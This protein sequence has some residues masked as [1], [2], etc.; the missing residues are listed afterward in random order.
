MQVHSTV[1]LGL[2]YS[3]GTTGRDTEKQK[4]GSKDYEP[5]AGDFNLIG[6]GCLKAHSVVQLFVCLFAEEARVKISAS[7]LP[8]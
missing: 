2:G 8:V 6:A 5:V 1:Q 7:F 3:I 4:M